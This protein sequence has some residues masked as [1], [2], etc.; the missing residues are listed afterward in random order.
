MSACFT[1]GTHSLSSPSHLSLL[2]HQTFNVSIPLNHIPQSEYTF[3]R[4]MSS[5]E[6]EEEEVEAAMLGSDAEGEREGDDEHEDASEKKEKKI[7]SE[8]R[9]KSTVTGRAIGAEGSPVE[10]TVVGSV[11]ALPSLTPSSLD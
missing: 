2:V 5:K 6:E 3:D 11:L 10:F 7:A 4:S 8:G 9:W 1:V